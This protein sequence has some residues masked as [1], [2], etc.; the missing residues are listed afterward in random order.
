MV[1]FYDFALVLKWTSLIWHLKVPLWHQKASIRNDGLVLWDYHVI[2]IQ[3]NASRRGKVFDLVW[4]LDSSL[5]FPSPINVYFS[6]AIQP[7][8]GQFELLD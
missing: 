6:E 4:D 7:T 2:C 8:S 3:V 5:P 1:Y